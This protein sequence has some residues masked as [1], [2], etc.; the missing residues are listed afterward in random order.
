MDH[1]MHSTM[2]GMD[3][4]GTATA[5][6]TGAMASSTDMSSMDHDMGGMGG[7]QISV[8][9][10]RLALKSYLAHCFEPLAK[11]RS[12]NAYEVYIIGFAMV[13]ALVGELCFVTERERF[14]HCQTS[15]QHMIAA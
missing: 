6:A 8:S 13:F 11:P 4:M 9:F 5:T 15:R 7:C 1:S 14:I 10:A 3:M 2:S 12:Y